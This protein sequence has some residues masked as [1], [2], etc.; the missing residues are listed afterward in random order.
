MTLNF[1]LNHTV[2][3]QKTQKNLKNIKINIKN[4]KT[5]MKN[6][7]NQKMVHKTEKNYKM[8][9]KNQKKYKMGVENS[10]KNQKNLKKIDKNDK[11][12]TI[13]EKTPKM[14]KKINKNVKNKIKKT[15]KTENERKKIKKHKTLHKKNKKPS[16]LKNT[17]LSEKL[18]FWYIILL[19]SIMITTVGF[20]LDG[21][22]SQDEI[23]N[24]Y[25][26][27]GMTGVGTL[28]VQ[29]KMTAEH[30]VR[31]FE[32]ARSNFYPARKIANSKQHSKNG[33]RDRNYKIL[34]WN[35]GS[36]LWKNKLLDLELLLNDR[37]PDLCFITEANLW[38]GFLDHE[39]QIAGHKLVFPLTM[40]SM[41]HS[42]IMLIIREDIE[43]ELMTEYMD[44]M[45]ATIWVKLGSRKKSTFMVGGVYREHTQL[46]LDNSNATKAEL[47]RDQERRWNLILKQWKKAGRKG[48]CI[49]IGDLNL[50]FLKWNDPDQCHS[51]MVEAVQ[52]EIETEGFVQI[53]SKFTRTWAMQNDSLLD[54]IWINCVNRVISHENRINSSSDHNSVE[55]TMAGK[56]IQDGGLN[57]RKRNWKKMDKV[58]FE[59]KIK[60]ENWNEVLLE[61]DPILAS[62]LLEDKLR[63]IL[64][65]EAPMTNIQKRTKY[66][67]WISVSTKDTMADRDRKREKARMTQV[68][69]DW[70]LYREARNLCT[71][72][73]RK[74]KGVHVRANFKRLETEADTG[75]LYKLT[76]KMLNW[77]Q[78]G[79]PTQFTSEGKIVRKE[80]DL[81]DLQ[82]LFYRDKVRN[83]KNLIPKVNR[84]PLKLLRNAFDRWTPETPVPIFHLKEV[85]REEILKILSNLKNSSAYGHDEIDA[86][87]LK[88]A[89]PVI[90]N[91]VMHV[92]NLSICTSIFPP[93][94]KLGRVIPLLKSRELNTNLPSSYRPVSQLSLL[95]KITEKVVQGQLLTFLESTNQLN[96]G[97]HAY[98]TLLSTSTAVGHI[99]D[100]IGEAIDNNKIAATMGIDQSA[101]FDCV[102]HALLME[103]LE[104]YNI[105][106]NCRNWIQSYLNNRSNYVSIGGAKSIITSTEYGVPQGSVLGP[107]LYLIYINDFPEIVEDDFCGN[108][109]HQDTSKLFGEGC[110]DC[111]FLPLYA[112]DA[113]LIV[114][115]GLRS[116]NQDNIQEKFDKIR[117][118]LNSHGLQIN[119][120]KT[121]LTEYMSHQKRSKISGL[122]PD[123]TVQE[124]IKGVISDKHITDKTTSKTLGI[125]I[126]NNLN[127]EPHLIG[128]K[129]AILPRIRKQMGALNSIMIN[130]NKKARL[131]VMNGLIMS[132]LVYLINIWGNTSENLIT[133]VQ[134]VQNKAGRI[135]T[136]YNRFT[137]QSKILKDCNWL[138]M[139]DITEYHSLIGFWKT[140]RWGKPAYLRNKL[141][142]EDN[143]MLSTSIPRLMTTKNAYRCK[144]TSR[145]NDLPEDLRNELTVTGFKR[146]L[147]RYLLDRNLVPDPPDDP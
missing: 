35:G 104:Y 87:T 57:I 41:K 144:T 40:K 82:A 89:A 45:T 125:T 136:G 44:E 128:S 56:D 54:H 76:R 100:I 113:L 4:K 59:N 133:K 47:Q 112:D 69:G 145:W 5:Q 143:N 64:D 79:P 88:M 141:Q 73:Q 91:A 84:D 109:Q 75:K 27:R 23:Y 103:K 94:W 123:L 98:R 147:K 117:D 126:K 31:V 21:R 92:V 110:E 142:M 132:K 36:R 78:A 81:A 16:K 137:R 1:S 19:C 51:K 17:S 7:K 120:S 15:I 80:K 42:R 99:T 146:R 39:T 53:V 138:N 48:R 111:G 108:P 65:S 14:T 74:D 63:G 20:P 8:F 85:R 97:H 66:V 43:Y 11:K 86:G 102:N 130:M 61:W 134:V 95:S 101:A 71:K 67:S 28:P 9:R 22:K 6:Q 52:Q 26:S 13:A 127:W 121:T 46:G 131:Q 10:M 107:L 124:L 30:S 70:D 32:F 83:I 90:A 62:S 37:R 105:D 93:K 72:L 60:N 12:G 114:I 49:L 140:L 115:S 58:R 38:E 116:R 2:E 55:V 68:P 18:S 34:H 50:D 106:E 25:I 29:Y 129:D 77:N 33:N 122:P 118:Y 3:K 96:N 24:D 139:R 119:E 135:I